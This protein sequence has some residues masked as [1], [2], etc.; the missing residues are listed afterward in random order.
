MP[1]EKCENCKWHDSFTWACFNGL[2]ERRA[3]FTDN[4]D[5]CEVWESDGREDTSNVSAT[6]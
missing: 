4:D 1:T 5:C 2:S 6:T 3:D